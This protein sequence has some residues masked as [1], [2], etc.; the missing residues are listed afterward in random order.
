MVKMRRTCQWDGLARRSM[1]CD[2]VSATGPAS[3]SDL[4]LAPRW[5]R[6][7]RLP[8]ISTGSRAYGG[9]P[10][11]EIV[12]DGVVCVDAGGKV[13]RM[14]RCSLNIVSALWQW[15]GSG[16]LGELFVECSGS[17]FGLAS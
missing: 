10:A 5:P 12:D 4:I 1:I 17:P 2:A 14:P 16:D 13:P 6:W 3:S 8:A 15:R 9:G 11:N 7:A